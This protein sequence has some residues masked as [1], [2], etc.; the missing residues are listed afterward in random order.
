MRVT[1]KYLPILAAFLLG[2]LL[3]GP[4]ANAWEPKLDN[5][6]YKGLDVF[7]RGQWDKAE[8]A[9][10]QKN[11]KLASA[12]FNKFIYEFGNTAAVGPAA[13]ME[14][15]C[16]FMDNKKYDAI[17]RYKQFVDFYGDDLKYA[18]AAMYY[19]GIAYIQ[20]GDT[21]KGLSQLEELVKE[22][23]Y[24]D[25]PLVGDALKRLAENYREN[26]DMSKYVRYATQV[27]TDFW[28]KDRRLAD[29][30]RH[31]LTRYYIKGHYY[32]K[33]QE[34]NGVHAYTNPPPAENAGYYHYV[35]DR[36][37][38]DVLHNRNLYP[39]KDEAK[40][41]EDIDA[42]WAFWTKGKPV[43]VKHSKWEYDRRSLEFL[44]RYREKETKLWQPFLDDILDDKSSDDQIRHVVRLLMNNGMLEQARALFPKIKNE[45]SFYTWY[46]QELLN[47][48]L[49]EEAEHVI[50]KIADTGERNWKTVD[51]LKRRNAWQDCITLLKDI[52]GNDPD[53]ARSAEWQLGW[54]YL[55]RTR[56]YED[57]VKI[58][59]AI[60]DPPRSSW[61]T[62]VAYERW[63]KHA[64]AAT[65][66]KEIEQF[67]PKDAS[68]ASLA[69][70]DMWLRYGDKEE[71]IS[72]FRRIL[73]IYKGTK[74]A[75]FAHERL[76]K[77]GIETGGGELSN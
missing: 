21:R 41:Q 7:A 4:Q 30:M 2:P 47:K 12:E 6:V 22:E 72:I 15:H 49:L 9:Y 11:Y 69:R 36:A 8:K 26:G 40:R 10:E 23:K 50:A 42:F 77:L 33:I 31:D 75:S 20:A 1:L 14:A 3:L 48:N 17:K 18:P 54:I 59:Q 34:L 37:Y 13:Y 56:Q 28:D 25:H 68:R 45:Q 55:H 16:L 67:F 58:Y 19:W 71:A 38:H 5:N 61:E 73:K 62:A 63:G 57:A 35:W 74:E 39:P 51:L 53:R 32:N 70:G 43:I 65:T 44:L 60:N 64:Q 66:Y 24:K 76:E 29:G 27:Y 46:A 52:V